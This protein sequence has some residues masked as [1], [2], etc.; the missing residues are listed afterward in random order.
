MVLSGAIFN[1]SVT[2]Q[3]MQQMAAHPVVQ[4][5]APVPVPTNSDASTGTAYTPP[6]TQPPTMELSEGSSTSQGSPKRRRMSPPTCKPYTTN[7]LKDPKHDD[8]PP[9]RGVAVGGASA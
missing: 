1:G 6:P 8:E 9:A 3:V 4:Q 7:I 2:I 5:I